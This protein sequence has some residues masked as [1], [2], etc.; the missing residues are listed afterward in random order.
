MMPTL[1]RLAQIV[2]WIWRA[3]NTAAA[4][5]VTAAARRTGARIT[6][7]GGVTL[8][9]A[10]RPSLLPPGTTAAAIGSTIIAAD[11]AALLD[12]ITHEGHHLLQAQRL[13]WLYLPVALVSHLLPRHRR[14]LELAAGPQ[15]RQ[16]N[17]QPRESPDLPKI[18]PDAA[19]SS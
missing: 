12:C 13:G 10:G 17:A 2:L 6:H 5:I 9:I 14:P 1:C 8:I 4:A 16:R 3:P 19:Q 11:P 7:A 15:L 18:P